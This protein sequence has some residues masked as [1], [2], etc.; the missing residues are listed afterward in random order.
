MKFVFALASLFFFLFP[1]D[2][3]SQSSPD[4]ITVAYFGEHGIHPGLK[5]GAAW[6]FR[7]VTITKTRR[8][9]RLANKYPP[10]NIRR[11]FFY[12]TALSYYHFPN[13]HDGIML[14]ASLGVRRIKTATGRF[15][16]VEL[17]LGGLQR[18]YN[19]D[20]VGLD[21]NGNL[22]EFSRRGITQFTPVIAA[23]LGRDMSESW[24]IPVSWFLKPTA[25]LGVP[26]VHVTTPSIALEIGLSLAL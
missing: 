14:T 19:L 11:E 13:N 12:G 23:C 9:T 26:Y 20:V 8:L 2:S 6:N 21:E 1:H 15:A 18:V 5:I 24:S 7:D 16:G 17:G 22:I 3:L 10:K 25:W 4:R